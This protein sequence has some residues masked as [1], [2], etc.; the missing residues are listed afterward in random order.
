M[1]KTVAVSVAM[2][3]EYKL[4]AS[5]LEN[6]VY[7]TVKGLEFCKAQKGELTLITAKSGVGKVNAAIAAT[8]LINEFAPD[9]IISSGVAGG[10]DRSV[11]IGDVVLGS[12]TCYHDVYMGKEVVQKTSRHEGRFAADAQLLHKAESLRDRF[13]MLKSG[14][15]CTGDQFIDSREKMQRIKDEYPEA[16][17]VDMESCSLAQ[18]CAHF[19]TPFMALRIISDTPY[20]D[21][22]LEKYADFFGKAPHVL[23]DIV[24][25]IINTIL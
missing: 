24:Q 18:T 4:L 17:A 2:D 12:E 15:I 13:P 8:I 14:L 5:S 6:A 10:L 20:A 21:R 19:N 9:C 3:A 11:D 7:L 16:L 22:H 23:F 1:G 25:T